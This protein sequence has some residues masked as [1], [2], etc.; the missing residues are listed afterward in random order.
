[1]CGPWQGLNVSRMGGACSNH[2]G[3]SHTVLEKVRLSAV[4]QVVRGGEQSESS[5]KEKKPGRCLC[6][7]GVFHREGGLAGELRELRRCCQRVRLPKPGGGSPAGDT[8]GLPS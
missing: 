5:S 8:G 6:G 4:R 2:G 3:H 1:M 7:W